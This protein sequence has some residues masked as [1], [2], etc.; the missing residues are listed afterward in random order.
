[1]GMD[2]GLPTPHVSSCCMRSPSTPK[3]T[4][5]NSV[6]TMPILNIDNKPCSE[7][8]GC[9]GRIT[10]RYYLLAADKQWHTECLRCTEC[11]LRLDD[12]LTCFA[13]DGNIYCKEDYYRR[14]SSKRCSRCNMGIPSGEMVMR[15]RDLVYHLACFSCALCNRTL[16]TGEHF[17]MKDCLVY[18]RMHYETMLHGERT[19]GL[20]PYT[21]DPLPNHSTNTLSPYYNGMGPVHKGRPRK[22]K[23]M[24]TTLDYHQGFDLENGMDRDGYG[25]QSRTKRMRT[26]FKHHQLRT[27]KSYFTL[28]HNPDAKD[29]KQ[30]AQKTGLTKRVLQVWFQNARAKYRR[31]MLKKDDGKGGTDSSNIEDDNDKNCT[32]DIEADSPDQTHENHSN[33]DEEEEHVEHDDEDDNDSHG[34]TSYIDMDGPPSSGASDRTSSIP[35]LTEL[36][37]TLDDHISTS[38]TT[39][40]N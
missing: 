26:S 34:S 6:M 21:N 9:R 36:Q 35:P 25:Q 30:L 31:T 18:C 15:A 22:R 7:C 16:T 12:Q 5:N 32:T 37:S 33:I 23:G 20:I 40:F 10:D 28:N 27:M 3:L 8:A 1:M 38:F 24:D 14:F 2:S 11:K 17:G 13:R 39:L 29:L 4:A 19:L